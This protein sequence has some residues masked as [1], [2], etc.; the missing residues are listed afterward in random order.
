MQRS[1]P[2]GRLFG[3]EVR[4]HATWLVAFALITWS[5]ASGYFRFQVRGESFLFY[6]GLGAL[7]AVL[8]F[9]SVLVHEFGHS[10]VAQALGLR[11]RNITLFI[12]GGVSSIGGEAR[13]ARDE[14]LISAVGP[15]TSFALAGVFWLVLQTLGPAPQLGALFGIGRLRLTA[16]IS[17]AAAVVGYLALINLVLGLFNLVPAFPLDGGR[18]FR[19]IVW[20][21]THNFDRATAIATT[22]GQGFGAL[23]IVLGG[24]RVLLFGDLLGGIWTGF[25][26]WFLTQAAGASRRERVLRQGLAGVQVGQLMDPTAPVVEEATS[27]T[28]LVY[29]RLLRGRDRDYVVVDDGGHPR[30]VV[31]AGDV[32]RAPRESW[33]TTPVANIM[34]PEVVTVSPSAEASQVLELIGDQKQVVAVVDD[35][36]LVGTLHLADLLRFAQLHADLNVGRP[37]ARPSAL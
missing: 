14:F 34:T 6:L 32:N 15:L 1:Y 37:A 9:A 4:V 10:L 23:L 25:I 21:I 13:T 17:P 31:S 27:I 28:S 35:G 30:G 7:S 18:V 36:R 3:I 8:L 33:A 16:G 11:V 20:A 26:G 29:G 22:V 5:L 19:S 24:V 12:F 2:L